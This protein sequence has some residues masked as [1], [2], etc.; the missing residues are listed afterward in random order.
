MTIEDSARKMIGVKWVHQGRDPATGVDCVGLGVVAARENG[1]KV[2]D[3]TNYS[4]DPD[5]TLERELTRILGEPVARNGAAIQPNDIVLM[6][7]ARNQPRHVGIIGSHAHGMS[8]IHA[9]NR[10]GAVCEILI[11]SRWR[12]RI[13]GVWRPA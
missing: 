12:K 8:M 1:Y 9:C 4:V 7:F 11:D 5:G 10:R 2:K 3:R 6:E 13:V